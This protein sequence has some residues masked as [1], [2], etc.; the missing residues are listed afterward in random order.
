L[1]FVEINTQNC[2]WAC[3]RC[4]EALKRAG[5]QVNEGS[6]LHQI[7]MQ[8]PLLNGL[9]SHRAEL[10]LCLRRETFWPTLPDS[11]DSNP[12]K[13]V[14]YQDLPHAV[15]LA[16]AHTPFCSHHAVALRVTAGRASAKLH[17]VIYSSFLS[18]HS[19]QAVPR[20]RCQQHKSCLR[21]RHI[22]RHVADHARPVQPQVLTLS[23]E[24]VCKP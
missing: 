1:R 7:V 22:L 18:S 23:P 3:S 20:A 11:V 8:V 17:V 21:H 4:V 6:R 5:A 19:P 15:K 10:L 2:F 9:T 16:G 12:R 13:P 14:Q 24:L